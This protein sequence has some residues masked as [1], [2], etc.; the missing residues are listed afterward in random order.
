MRVCMCV[1]VTTVPACVLY[2]RVRARITRVITENET[3]SAMRARDENELPFRHCH[4]SSRCQPL[5]FLFF[6]TGLLCYYY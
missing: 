3:R 6:C 4:F 5:F 2:M 1:Y